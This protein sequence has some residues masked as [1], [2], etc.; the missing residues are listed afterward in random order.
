VERIPDCTGVI[1][2]GGR[3]RRMGGSPKALSRVGGATLATRSVAL[4][5]ELFGEVLVVANDPAPWELLGV[6]VV[7]DAIPGKGAPGGLHAALAAARTGW[8][9]AAACDMPFLSAGPIRFLAAQRGAAPAALV[10]WERGTEGLH[11][12]WSRD[13]LP[14]VEQM[15]REGDPSIREI[16]A[17]VGARVVTAEAWRAVDPLGRSFENVNSPEDLVRLGLDA[18]FLAHRGGLPR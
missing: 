11:A 3:A 5:R 7:P 2:A 9:F 6:S 17:R 15:V 1:V 12:F 14:V 8:I 13:V 10:A 18:P 16:A 4:F